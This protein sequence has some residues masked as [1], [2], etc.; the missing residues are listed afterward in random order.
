MLTHVG[1]EHLQA[2]LKGSADALRHTQP[3][4]LRLAGFQLVCQFL[5]ALAHKVLHITSRQVVRRWRLHVHITSY[6]WAYF[7]E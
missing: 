3:L 1:N 7:L 5:V 2:P 6:L 4:Q